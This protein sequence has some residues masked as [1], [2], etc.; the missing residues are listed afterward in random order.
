MLAFS[1]V[2]GLF[3]SL[4]CLQIESIIEFQF[5]FRPSAATATSATSAGKLVVEGE[6]DTD[7]TYFH[8]WQKSRRGIHISDPQQNQSLLEFAKRFH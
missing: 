3:P 6:G 1:L 5:D 7:G 8:R 2:S 4:I